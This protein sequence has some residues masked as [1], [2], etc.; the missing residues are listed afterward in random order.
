MENYNLKLEEAK[1]LSLYSFEVYA[2]LEELKKYVESKTQT[3]KFDLIAKL[4]MGF[5]DIELTYRYDYD[6]PLDYTCC[7]ETNEGWETFEVFDV[8]TNMDNLRADILERF[9][10]NKIMGFAKENELNWSK[11]NK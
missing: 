3:W 11:I 4:E 7:I 5:M 10:F 9:M 6:C 8:E 2:N 1:K